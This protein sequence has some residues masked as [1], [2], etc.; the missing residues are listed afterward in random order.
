MLRAF[1]A[2]VASALP[3]L[4]QRCLPLCALALSG[5]LLSPTASAKTAMQDYV[6]AMQPG[7]NLGNTLDATP[8]ETAW[9]NV[10]TTQELIQQIKAQGFKSIRIPIT[11]D[12]GG[13]VGPAP[14]YTIDSAFLDRVQQIVDWSLDAGLY[15]MINLHHDSGWV[16]TMPTH[17]DEVLAKFNALWSQIAPRFRDH[18]DKLHFESINEPTFEGVDGA[19]KNALLKELNVSFHSIVRG[20][21]GGNATRPLVLPT[22]ETSNAQENLDA[23]A[24]TIEELN[25]PNL[26][27]TVHDYGY[28]PFSVNI[29]GVTTFDETTLNW[30]K[31]GV[32]A[33]YE[34]FVSKGIPVVIGEFGLLSF[35]GYGG[36]VER[37]EALKFFEFLTSY[38]RSKGMTHQWWDAGNFFDRTAYQ[39]RVPEVYSIVQQSV[40]GRSSTA[41]TDL[42]FLRDG[43]PLQDVVI[44]LN[45]NGN[46]F[47]SLHD[48]ET[49]LTLGSDYTISGSTLTIKASAL[50]PYA[51]GDFGEKTV[52]TANFTSGPGW[53]FFVHHDSAPALA[54]ASGTK[55]GGLVIPTAFNGDLLATMEGR[56]V[57]APNYPHPGQAEWTPFQEY[58]A[59]YLPDY[60][61]NRILI[62]KEFTAATNNE[63]IDLTFHFWSGRKVN[64]RLTF[65][66]GGDIIANPQELV[67]YDDALNHD[68]GNWSW[69]ATNDASE[70]LPHSG[71][72]SIAVDADA[73]S[74]VFLGGGTIDRPDYR[75][76]IFWAHGGAVGGQTLVVSAS[77]NWNFELPSI[78]LPPLQAN[79]W[80]KFEVPLDA[81]G[82]AENPNIT[83]FTIMNGSSE[84]APRFYIDDIKLTT[85]YPSGIVFVHGAPAPVITSA[86]SAT[87]T[88]NAPF[89]YQIEAINAPTSFS[90]TELPPGLTFDAAT[91]VISGVPTLAGSYVVTI[92]AQND[93]GFGTAQ[94][95]IKIAPSTVAIS[96]PGG[97]GPG[98]VFQ[99]AYDGGPA[100]PGITT[101]PANLP[102]TVTYNGSTTPPTLPGTYHVVVTSNHPNYVGSAEGTLEITVTALVRHAPTLNG[103]LDGSLQLLSGESFTINGSASVSGDLLLPGTPAVQLNGTPLFGGIVDATGAASP[104]N[105]RLTLNGGAV[106]RYAVR[107]VD[108]LP[109]PVVTE[110]AQPSGTRDVALNKAGQSAGDFATLRNLTLNGNVGSVTVPSG[111]YGH[112]TANGNGSLVLGVAGANEPAVYELQSLTLNGNAS[113]QIVGPVK[114]KLATGTRIGGVSGSAAHPEWLDLQVANG[115]VTVQ[116]GG[117]L[118]AI[119]T[120]PNGTVVIDGQLHGRVSADRLT[121]NG[122]GALADPAE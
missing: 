76:L 65:E 30:T 38:Y 14:D 107:R 78:T 3:S 71:T 11:W 89:H 16:S 59:A 86:I 118:H 8:N 109:M 10:P 119:V 106:V 28:W 33:V 22:V 79:T 93:A 1:T 94:L 49:P 81:I 97:S 100:A 116:G 46:G 92:G 41:A 87:G 62:R 15:V 77:E 39:W 2:F 117:V 113:L 121:I 108:P 63:P 44:P 25:D 73:W 64:Y 67:L 111:V 85:A 19:T 50:A 115:G 54:A 37:G 6:E 26:I 58:N 120:A 75:T 98:A 72:R 103:D 84:P 114:L 91:G 27:V 83:T 34:T 57:N 47:L 31:T 96:L 102:V 45:L 20:T 61:N 42:I 74:A 51:T 9:G 52:L 21:G 29:T 53:K 104:N 5:F 24:A 122:S 32:D 105:Y 35:G 18:S 23:L 36:A 69:A 68:W 12:T 101:I 66:P 43:T 70:E 90:A 82:V 88:F 56:H 80:T 13:R 110:P 55:A 95:A 60:A 17:H 40:V 4:F 99:L 112:F 48:G 7:W